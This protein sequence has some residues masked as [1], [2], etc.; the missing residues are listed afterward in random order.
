MRSLP[1][2][3]TA[4][5]IVAARPGSDA[6]AVTCTSAESATTDA[7]MS[8]ALFAPSVVTPACCSA[9]VRIKSVSR[10]LAYVPT[11]MERPSASTLYTNWP[12][13]TVVLGPIS[14]LERARYVRGLCQVITPSATNTPTSTSSAT[15]RQRHMA[16]ATQA[17]E[18]E[19]ISTGHEGLVDGLQ[20]GR[21]HW[22]AETL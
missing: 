1:I 17:T 14:K 20:S 4:F 16:A 19:S 10:T 21:V 9:S 3:P 12:G 6:T 8:I 11:I 18:V 2:W 22:Q 5:A 7:L 15:H 13:S